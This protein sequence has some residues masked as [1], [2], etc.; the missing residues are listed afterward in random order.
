[1]SFPDNYVEIKDR[2]SSLTMLF[3]KQDTTS[4][5]RKEIIAECAQFHEY[6]AGALFGIIGHPYEF[7]LN[8]QPY[9]LEYYSHYL[10]ETFTSEYSLSLYA[11]HGDNKK[12]LLQERSKG[13]SAVYIKFLKLVDFIK[14]GIYDI[15]NC[16][17]PE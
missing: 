14:D 1:M 11:G 4:Q 6:L 15:D 2:I 10:L 17:I 7:T 5:Q 9:T 16:D 13:K 3:F 8:G 12:L